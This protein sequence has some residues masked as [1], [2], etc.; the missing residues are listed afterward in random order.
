M[1]RVV[2]IRTLFATRLKKKTEKRTSGKTVNP[3]TIYGTIE[4]E[5]LIVSQRVY[6]LHLRF[7][8]VL[9]YFWCRFGKSVQ[10]MR[11]IKRGPP[12]IENAIRTLYATKYRLVFVIIHV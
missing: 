3:Y 9:I 6:R 1:R 8:S 10:Y 12:K 4:P 7:G 5:A 2:S 11:N